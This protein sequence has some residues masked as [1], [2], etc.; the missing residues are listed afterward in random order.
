MS[1]PARNL[2]AMH[3]SRQRRLV[4]IHNQK[5]GG[6]S[7]RNFLHRFVP[8]MERL[9]PEHARAVHGIARLGREE[10][11]SYYSFGFVRNPWA[12]LVSWYTM[13]VERPAAGQE[14]AWW[15]YVRQNSTN[16]EEFLYRCTDTIEERQDGCVVQ[17]SAMR[18]QIDYFTD[19]E[20]GQAVTFIGRF[21]NLAGDFQVVRGTLG[22]PALPLWR[23]NPTMRKDY[24][25]YYTADTRRLVAQRFARDIARFD[26]AFEDG[27]S[28]STFEA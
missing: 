1:R 23:A 13:I 18:N 25:T 8:D 12:R 11:D 20:G 27:I 14:S 24:R 4:F 22:L 15:R 26:Y 17:R 2:D 7:I 10:W 28:S 3:I 5:T 9:L 19:A 21:E 6:T 16:F